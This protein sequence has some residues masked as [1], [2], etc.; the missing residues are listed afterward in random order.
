MV[1]RPI[2]EDWLV[3]WMRKHVRCLAQYLVQNR[4]SIN[5][6]L[7][8]NGGKIVETSET[9]PSLQCGC[10]HVY[11]TYHWGNWNFPSILLAA[12]LMLAAME[13]VTHY[14]AMAAASWP[15]ENINRR[16]E[17]GKMWIVQDWAEPVS[18]HREEGASGSGNFPF[19]IGW[20]GLKTTLSFLKLTDLYIP[21]WSK[22]SYDSLPPEGISEI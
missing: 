16:V 14:L 8:C 10:A 2:S 11:H 15:G 12:P 5:T 7:S 18:L 22:H 13:I 1:A 21:Q 6:F 20:H 3:D 19:P 9:T 17:I 4:S